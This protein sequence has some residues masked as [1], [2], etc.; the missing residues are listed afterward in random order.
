MLRLSVML[1]NLVLS[2]GPVPTLGALTHEDDVGQL[3]NVILVTLKIGCAA[4]TFVTHVTCRSQ[5]C[6]LLRC[7]H[8]NIRRRDASCN[9]NTAVRQRLQGWLSLWPDVAGMSRACSVEW[10]CIYVIGVSPINGRS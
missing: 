8:G 10:M 5:L 2:E 3:V 7:L 9:R 1:E 4:E 6:V